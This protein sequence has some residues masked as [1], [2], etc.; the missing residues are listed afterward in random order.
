MTEKKRIGFQSKAKK[1]LLISGVFICFLLLFVFKVH[2]EM[3]DFE[4]YYKS[5][6]RLRMAENLYQTKDEHYMFK[7]PPPSS[8]LF[9][10]MSFL[11]LKVAKAAWYY[12][13]ILCLFSLVF[14]SYKMIPENKINPLYLK[15]I[16]PLILAK[17]MLR[18]I[19]LGQVNALI[20]LILLLMIANISSEKNRASS[21][22]QALSGIYWGLATILKPY[23]LIFLPY[24]L[25]KRKWKTIL[26]GLGFIGF[27]SFIPA[28]FYGISGNIW[29]F[30]QWISTL[31]QSTPSLITSQDNISLLAFFMKWSGNMNISLVGFGLILSVLAVCVLIVIEKGKTIPHASLLDCSILLILIPLIS[32]LGWDYILLMSVA[33][34]MI[35]VN[36]YHSFPYFWRGMMIF[37]FSI[38]AFSL[39]DLM[40][41]QMYATFMSWSVLTINFLIIIGYLFYLRIKKII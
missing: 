1:A 21:R 27:S 26:S 12:V 14:L 22:N 2:D 36:H 25:L 4:V 33:G 6:K 9:V 11:P 3:K 34:V 5:G 8:V 31:S 30:K 15:I 32:P 24:F 29:I 23:A 38:I 39:Y 18:E 16:P 19:Q 37:N 20:T 35:V 13:V 10:P 41:R 28:L 40:E 17:L 7:Y